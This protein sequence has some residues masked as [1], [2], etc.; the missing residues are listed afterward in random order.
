MNFVQKIAA[1]LVF[2]VGLALADDFMGLPIEEDATKEDRPLPTWIFGG[3]A[4]L[5]YYLKTFDGTLALDAE[6]RVGRH[7]SLAFYGMFPFVA[8]FLEFGFDWRWYF[9][10][11]LMRSGHD[12]FLKF[13][14]SAFYL[15]YDETYFSPAFSFGYG[16][17]ILFFKKADLFGRFEFYGSYVVGHPVEKEN[18]RLPI[19]EPVR[20][21]LH[22]KASILFF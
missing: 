14:V 6:Y 4:S 2:A 21:F 18:E 8:D 19:T 1:V 12:D 16:R 10:G 9:K 20:F 13:S 15:D 7:H 17:D 11:S 3:G 22:L 5:A